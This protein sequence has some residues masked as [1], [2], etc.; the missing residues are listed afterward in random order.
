MRILTNI[1]CCCLVAAV[2]V[3][4]GK[5]KPTHGKIE[6]KVR[7]T[8][9]VFLDGDIEIVEGAELSI[10]PG[11][12]VR[13]AGTDFT[14]G[15]FRGD[16]VEI[17]VVGR[18]VVQGTKEQ[19]VT[20]TGIH[21][22]EGKPVVW[23]GIVHRPAEPR[24]RRTEIAYARFDGAFT[25]VQVPFGSPRIANCVFLHCKVGVEVGTAYIDQ[26]RRGAKPGLATP[27]IRNC[28]F[29]H[30]K[31]GVYA[32]ERGS[33]DV[34]HS[35]FYRCGVGVGNNRPGVS[36]SLEDPGVVV[37]RT[38]FLKCGIGIL[39][40]G[41]VQDSIFVGNS[42][43]IRLSNFHR[44]FTNL[45]DHLAVRHNLYHDNGT[46]IEGDTGVDNDP[47]QGDPGF[48]GPLTDLEKP[49]VAL[50]PCLALR[51][52]SKAKGKALDGGDLGPLGV[53]RG[54]EGD[55]RWQPAGA[56]VTAIL[57]L[58]AP[59]GQKAGGVARSRPSLG[60]KVGKQ[61]WA[62]AP[63]G[64]Q[65]EVDMSGLFGKAK[66]GWLAFTAK[67]NR[68]GEVEIELNGDVEKVVAYVSGKPQE[69]LTSRYRFG[70]VGKRVKIQLKGG[71]SF[72]VLRV[73]GWGTRPRLGIAFPKGVA[74]E[75]A[76]QPKDKPLEIST[77]KIVSR[78]GERWIDVTVKSVLHWAETGKSGS[79]IVMDAAGKKL[80]GTESLAIE[81]IGQK[82]LK[83]LDVPARWGKPLQVQLLD[84]RGA[85][86]GRLTKGTPK[87]VR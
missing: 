82:R 23:H 46:M 14:K 70:L 66:G 33:P 60:K 8:G 64:P 26:R 5:V 61:W 7:W 6:G 34:S 73:H 77:G 59:A 11:T 30:C 62:A 54:P 48:V 84:L 36:Y 65:S 55:V 13:I 68:A 40:Q 42:T 83:I 25:G 9:E 45:I 41:L 50:P 32:E 67:G 2:A 80:E 52:D 78:R 21:E 20:F 51:S 86:G 75:T 35:V 81:V 37:Q 10:A 1:L 58:P 39:G 17:Q 76:K 24:G 15:G 44:L 63:L 49:G 28:R 79:A 19:P 27:E 71:K 31:T 12:N 43:A 72:V 69:L 22:G 4:Q 47:I 85:D 18:L 29:A 3:G 87:P 16:R 74:L 57:G 38:A 53:F 56:I